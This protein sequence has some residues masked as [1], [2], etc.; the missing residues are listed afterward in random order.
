MNIKFSILLPAASIL[1]ISKV[2]IAQDLVPLPLDITSN[3]EEF[4]LNDKTIINYHSDLEEQAMLLSE[5]LSP[6]TGFDIEMSQ[7]EKPTHNVIYLDLV[8]QMADEGYQLDV[9]KQHVMIKAR[10]APGIFTV[11]K[12]F[13]NCFRLKYIAGNESKKLSGVL[14]ELK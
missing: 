6:A 12:R 8:D 11:F 10:S 3:G 9:T 7:S 1:F 4:V 2:L 14:K 13:D 5:F